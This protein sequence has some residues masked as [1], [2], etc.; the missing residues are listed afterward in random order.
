[1]RNR[2]RA[3]VHLFALTGEARYRDAIDDFGASQP[4]ALTLG[5]ALV[6]EQPLVTALLEY[7]D[8]PGATASVAD[9]WRQQFVATVNGPAW[10]TPVLAERDAYR[11]WLP[12]PY[13]SWGSTRVRA[14]GALLRL[15]LLRFDLAPEAAETQRAA[16]EGVLHSFHG[17]NPPGLTYLT[18]MAPFGSRASVAH[19]FH[20]WFAGAGCPPPPSYLTGGANQHDKPDPSADAS[21]LTT[22]LNQPVLKSYRDWNSGWP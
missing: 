22:P 17:V 20:A 4:H 7:S 14:M 21:R 12:G 3:A 19:T 5:E 1:M 6:W 18:N 9:T 8:L 16:A 10:L 2:V 15:D 11:A 13:T